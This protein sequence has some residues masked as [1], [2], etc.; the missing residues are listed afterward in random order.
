MYK[1]YFFR[2]CYSLATKAWAKMGVTRTYTGRTGP[3]WV[4]IARSVVRQAEWSGPYDYCFRRPTCRDIAD[5]G[6]D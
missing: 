6:I 1:I 5:Y 2:K 4:L 3:R